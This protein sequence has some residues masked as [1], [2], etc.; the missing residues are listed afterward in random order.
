M[1][2]TR[3]D[4]D[5]IPGPKK[6]DP[7]IDPELLRQLAHAEANREAL[8]AVF[9]LSPQDGP[10]PAPDRVEEMTRELVDRAQQACGQ[11][12]EDLSIFSHLGSFV[13]R[14]EPR[15]IRH[16]LEQPEIGSASANASPMR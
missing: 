8:E 11:A 4:G 9:V 12:V 7:R 13:T 6:P 3:V 5:I 1:K 10:P 15:L 2:G 16:L 14:A